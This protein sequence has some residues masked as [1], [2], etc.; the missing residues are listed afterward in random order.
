VS[1]P[2]EVTSQAARRQESRFVT[3][4]A[5]PFP[6]VASREMKAQKLVASLV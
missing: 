6:I 2:A 3:L 5:I 4:T 1:R